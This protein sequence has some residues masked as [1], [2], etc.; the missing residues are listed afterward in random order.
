MNARQKLNIDR[1][2]FPLVSQMNRCGFITFAS[3]QGHGYPCDRLPPYI[4]FYCSS[5]KARYLE[6]LLREDMESVKPELRWGWWVQGSFDSCYRLCWR[7][8]PVGAHYWYS[9]YTR[10]SVR[11]DITRLTHMMVL[12]FQ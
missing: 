3:C 1:E 11:H 6:R 8:Q 5:G 12:F 10:R 7:L 2:I 4:A 9:R